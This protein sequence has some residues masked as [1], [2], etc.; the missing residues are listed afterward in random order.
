MNKIRRIIARLVPRAIIRLV[1]IAIMPYILP[2][3]YKQRL[4]RY[5]EIE[6]KTF[7]GDHESDFALLRM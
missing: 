2:R 4:A 1:T 7:A 5:V 6:K 3:I